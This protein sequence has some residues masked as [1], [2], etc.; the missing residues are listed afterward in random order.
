MIF[1]KQIPYLHMQCHCQILGMR[2][3]G[4]VFVLPVQNQP[5]SCCPFLLIVA[6]PEPWTTWWD[7]NSRCLI[8]FTQEVILVRSFM[9]LLI[10]SMLNNTLMLWISCPTTKCSPLIPWERLSQVYSLRNDPLVEFVGSNFQPCVVWHILVLRCTSVTSWLWSMY[11]AVLNGYLP[12]AD[13]PGG[14]NMSYS[15]FS[16][17]TGVVVPLA[18]CDHNLPCTSLDILGGGP[19]FFTFCP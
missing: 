13:I 5:C 8:S 18:E 11:R 3:A 10:P 9:C 7:C 12:T 2:L 15:T 19:G 16:C 4:S 17:F 14:F 6:G 1:H